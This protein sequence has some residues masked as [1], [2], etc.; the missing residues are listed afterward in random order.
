MFRLIF[1][2][3]ISSGLMSCRTATD[4]PMDPASALTPELKI[5]AVSA[6]EPPSPGPY[7]LTCS[8]K[9]AQVVLRVQTHQMTV[10][11]PRSVYKKNKSKSDEIMQENCSFVPTT[12]GVTSFLCER[13]ST[14][15]RLPQEL[16]N[17]MA[18]L[19]G[20]KSVDARLALDEYAREKKSIKGRLVMFD[21]GDDGAL[22]RSSYKEVISCFLTQ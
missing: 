12:S 10:R 19:G 18:F 21:H 6:V 15:L 22:D 13:M 4:R 8:G 20:S 7:L 16:A 3:V 17:A 1:I 11:A 9:S 5:A 14:T 2:F